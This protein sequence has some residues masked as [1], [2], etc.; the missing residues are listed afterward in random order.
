MEEKITKTIIPPRITLKRTSVNKKIG[1]EIASSDS[2]D[3]AELKEIVLMME[4]I[5]QDMENIFT[6][7]IKKEGV[8]K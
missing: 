4:E 1:W 2:K 8:Q 5:N 3:K 7:K 6:K